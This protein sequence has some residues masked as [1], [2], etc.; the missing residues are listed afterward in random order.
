MSNELT[1]RVL[2]RFQKGEGRSKTAAFPPFSKHGPPTP[3]NGPSQRN[4]PK[5]H[6]FDPR[7]LKPMSQALWATSVSLGHALTAY[8]QLNRLKSASVSPDGLLGGRG[9]IMGVKDARQKLYD[10]CEALSSIADTLYDEIQ[11]PHWKPKLAMLDDNDAEDVSRYVEESQDI[12]ENPEADAEKDM[13]AIEEEN[14]EP[15]KKSL[16]APEGS[17]MP[18]AGP[19]EESEAR[20]PKP[21]DKAAEWEKTFSA[22]E[23]QDDLRGRSFFAVTLDDATTW[24][25]TNTIANRLASVLDKPIKPLNERVVERLKAANSSLPVDTLPGPRVDRLEPEGGDGPWGSYN[26]DE[27]V[28]PDL[29]RW[30]PDNYDYPSEWENNLHQAESMTPSDPDTETEGWD[31]GLGYGAHGQGAGGYENPSGETDGT[32]G[33]WGPHSGLPGSPNL[34]PGDAEDA[35]IDVSLNDRQAILNSLLPGDTTPPVARTDYYD[36]M[37]DN[38][39]QSESELPQEVAPWH[40]EEVSMVDTMTI[41]E[42][43]QTPYVR[44]DYNTPSYRDDPLHNWPQEG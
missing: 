19:Q 37:K 9:Y 14:D 18:T 22:A 5:D 29:A 42:D 25:T 8:R 38:L 32:Q 2:T 30:D 43:I 28:E 7:A 11:A 10:A 26:E 44:Y 31:F 13:K 12:L 36:G 33:V 27:E 23:A 20:P 24:E 39:V 34:S 35:Y 40:E 41:N 17:A 21:D 6:P 15:K 3:P 16:D 4:I 1:D